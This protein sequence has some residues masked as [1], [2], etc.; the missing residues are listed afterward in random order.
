MLSL[1]QGKIGCLGGFLLAQ[2]RQAS[3]GQQTVSLFRKVEKQKLCVCVRAAA[4][5]VTKATS[6]TLIRFEP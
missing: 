5:Q 2:G 3:A 1:Q 6:Q 4:F